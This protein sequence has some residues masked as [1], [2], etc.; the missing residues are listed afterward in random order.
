MSENVT[1]VEEKK[2]KQHEPLFHIIKR[3]ALPI[4]NSLAIR[5]IAILLALAVVGLFTLIILGENPFKA[6]ATMFRGVFGANTLRSFRSTA[7]LLCIA[8]ALTPAF[9]MRFWNT[10][11][12]GQVLMGA[13]AS[14]FCL[15]YF[16]DLP[17]FWLVTLM[18]VFSLVMGT[19]WAVIPA[20]FKAFFN[21]NETL[22]TLMMNSVASCLTLF[23][24]KFWNKQSSTVSNQI[25]DPDGKINKIWGTNYWAVIITVLLI[26]AFMYVYLKYSKHG[27]EISVV[28]ESENTA[29]Y[30]GIDVKKVIIRTMA[31]SG[32]VCGLAGFLIVA[33][34]QSISGSIV[35]GQGFTA[36]MVAWLAKFNPLI[37]ILSAF[38]FIFVSVGGQEISTHLGYDLAYAD[39]LIG[40]LLF[41]IIGCEFFINYKLIPG[42]K[43][44]GF[45]A[46]FSKKSSTA[47]ESEDK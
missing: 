25:L 4:K 9:K 17:T 42:S 43:L 37:M 29:K 16:Y 44:K 31:I 36:I 6:Y 34:A 35:A 39:I 5:I 12:E 11:A 21:T 45:F 3:S 41:F 32:L 46:K 18:V 38:L 2:Q 47:A 28:G 27:Y 19:I 40:I 33:P 1:T 15:Y 13:L 20:I 24:M 30:V 8:L 10:G 23:F 7:V 22:F 26:C 14:A